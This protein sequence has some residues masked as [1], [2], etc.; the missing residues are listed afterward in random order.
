[1]PHRRDESLQ[2]ET[3]L[4]PL[5]VRSITEAELSPRSLVQT[6]TCGWR[7]RKAAH[8]HLSRTPAWLSVNTSKPQMQASTNVDLQDVT[9]SA[10]QSFGV[11]QNKCVSCF[12]ST[13][14]SWQDLDFNQ[15]ATLGFFLAITLSRKRLAFMGRLSRRV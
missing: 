3:S 15:N 6:A 7:C 5:V 13:E 1:M 14:R 9:C 12:Y 2:Q 4:H 8:T 11:V 10:A